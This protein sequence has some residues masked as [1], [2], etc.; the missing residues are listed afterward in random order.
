MVEAAGCR[1]DGRD[2]QAVVDHVRPLFARTDRHDHALGRVD[3]RLELLDAV[4]AHVGQRCGA[5]LIFFRLQ[6]AFLGAARKI[7]HFGRDPRQRLLVRPGDDRG[8]QPAGDADRNRNVGAAIFNQ[9]VASKADVAFGNFDQRHGER[10]DQHVIDR[11]LDAAAREPGVDL[12]SQLEQSVELNIDRQVNVRD[13]LLRLGQ[14]PRDCLAHVAEL[15]DFVRDVAWF[16]RRGLRGWRGLWRCLRTACALAQVGPDNATAGTAAFKTGEIDPLRFGQAA[17]ERGRFDAVTGIGFGC[18]R[19][20]GRCCRGF[21]AAFRRRRGFRLRLFLLGR[22]VRRSV[23]FG[24]G[25]IGALA[26]P[27]HDRDRGADLDPIR[28]F[29]DQYLADHT[30][31]D[32]FEFHRR[33]VGFDFGQQVARFDRIA[34]LDQPFGQRPLLHR[35]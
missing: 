22:G 33:F 30:L 2:L 12:A 25:R 27:R 3:H 26:L 13:L 24:S 32:R 10:L 5:A 23:G 14:P 8:D 9:C 31:V 20:L 35:R 21:T 15:D 1:H 7:T 19:G 17:C 34:F 28:S 6:L 11:K 16:D 18:G 4:H 29:G